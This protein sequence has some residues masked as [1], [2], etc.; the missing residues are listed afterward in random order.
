M[1]RLIVGVTA[2]IGVCA[3][4]A[5]IGYQALVLA[6]GPDLEVLWDAPAFSLTD[7]L[8]RPLRSGELRGKVVVANFVYTSCQDICPGLSAE[9]QLLQGR[10]REDGLLGERVQ[11]LSFTV[12]PARDTPAVLRAYAERFRAD[13]SAWR[14]LTG[15]EDQLVP[16]IVDGFKLGVRALPLAGSAHAGHTDGS[17]PAQITHSGR[18]VLIDREG[19]VRATYDGTELDRERVL[20][21][22][23]RLLR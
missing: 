16:L 5:L 11:L 17:E 15:P 1:R 12:D 20:R 21:D 2:A 13:P 14:F 19:R 22:V 8:E 7:Q 10:L 3:L 6:Q 4:L 9:M 23:R 18:F